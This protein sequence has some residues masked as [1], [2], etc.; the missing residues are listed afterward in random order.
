MVEDQK[1]KRI[2]KNA[3]ALTV[4]M[5]LVMFVGLFT[6]R[7]VLRSLGI[8]DYGIYGV[9][10]GVVG[11]ASFLNF[12]MA[13][14]TS[15]FI[16]L[17]LGRGDQQSMKQV[18]SS[19]MIIM[20]GLCGIVLLFAET[21]GLWFLN[22]KMDFP[23]DKMVAVN[24]LYQFTVI[25]MIFS[26]TQVPYTAEILAH[27]DMRIYAYIEIFN[28]LS[29]LLIA[30]SLYL[31]AGNRL[32]IYALLVLILYISV[33]IFYRFYAIR[34]YPE[35][36]LSSHISRTTI[37]DMLK[38]A[39]YDLYG[40]MCLTVRSQGQPIVLNM[41]FGVVANAGASIAST[42]SN[43]L[44]GFTNTVSQAFRP[45]IIKN[46]AA[47]NLAEMET[48][49]IRAAQFSL[50][51]YS[52]LTIPFLIETPR[53]MLLWL[54]ECPPYAVEFARFM[55]LSVG[56]NTLFGITMT[57]IHANGNLKIVSFVLGSNHILSLLIGYIVLRLGGRAWTMYG[58]G[59]A[60]N[61]VNFCV[62][63][64]FLT[65]YI[66]EFRVKAYIMKILNSILI[67]V[68]SALPIICVLNIIGDKL[69][70][71]NIILSENIGILIGVTIGYDLILGLLT[72]FFTFTKG[73]RIFIRQFIKSKIVI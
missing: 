11:T 49:I 62:T 16:T 50:L 46:Y 15:R 71:S 23:A 24:I 28:T 47:G 57:G 21:I 22:N 41:F 67:I 34:H 36:R 2:A 52:L 56:M 8:V 18:F 65:K 69:P 13:S 4:R 17:E 10:G 72:Y 33:T 37:I 64:F 55:V 6:T 5:I 9:V 27:E 53:I 40:N 54:G 25:S 58:I 66:S 7:I 38:F 29:K 60:F 68:I 20:L 19:S 43:C 44:S 26:Y 12:A 70:S 14:A 51:A 30:Y 42:V 59:L 45:Q 32:V 3:I 73:E 39:G 61:F 31:F 35:A 48:M 63:L 1:N